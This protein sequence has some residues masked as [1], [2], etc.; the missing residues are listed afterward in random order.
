MNGVHTCMKTCADTKHVQG[1]VQTQRHTEE[2]L[3]HSHEDRHTLEMRDALFIIRIRITK[4]II[5]PPSIRTN[6]SDQFSKAHPPAIHG[7]F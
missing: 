5:C 3:E 7:G 2:H 6:V 4:R 1:G